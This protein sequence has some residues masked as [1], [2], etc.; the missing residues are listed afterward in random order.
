MKNVILVFIVV[1]AIL[2]SCNRNC[3]RIIEGEITDRFSEQPISNVKVV[4]EGADRTDGFGAQFYFHDTVI[5][6]E[7]GGFELITNDNVVV[8]NYNL[9]HDE[10]VGDNL[11]QSGSIFDVSCG[12]GFTEITMSAI[13]YVDLETIDDPEINGSRATWYTEYPTEVNSGQLELTGISTI[14]V[15]ANKDFDIE[16]SIYDA[17]DELVKEEIIRVN[18]MKGEVKPVQIT[19]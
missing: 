3:E 18:L 4:A 7:Q 1:S 10:Y 9:L 6:D 12:T 11:F 16:V 19:I 15:L 14:P 8:W 17:L 2:Y 5:T 13:A